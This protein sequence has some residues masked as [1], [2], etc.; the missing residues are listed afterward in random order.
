[1]CMLLLP[2]ATDDDT[3]L[4]RRIKRDVAER[5]RDVM[6]VLEQ[7]QR[8]VKPAFDQFV[9]PSR[10]FADVIIPWQEGENIVAIDLVTEHIKTKLQQHSLRRIYPNLEVMPLT[11]QVNKHTG[12]QDHTWGG[13]A[14]TSG[15]T[16]RSEASGWC[17]WCLAVATYGKS[18]DGGRV[19]G[20]GLR[21]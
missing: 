7:Y 1:M 14:S 17:P 16:G 21:V 9:A 6:N 2:L 19:M 5:G 15:F 8:F 12:N 13:H 3:R 11:K 10:R 4:M 20:V 18:E